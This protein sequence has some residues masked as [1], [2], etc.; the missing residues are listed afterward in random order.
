LETTLRRAGLWEFSPPD[1]AALESVQPFC[2]DTL[3]L[4]QWLQWIFLPRMRALIDARGALPAKCGIAAMAEVRFL[5][6]EESEVLGLIELLRQI[7][8]A[9]EAG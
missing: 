1:P 3:D 6:R 2:V 9:I 8:A 4:P 5:G 7:D